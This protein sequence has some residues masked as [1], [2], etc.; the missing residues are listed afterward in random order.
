M[1]SKTSQLRHKYDVIYV[2]LLRNILYSRE[3][4]RQL[5]DRERLLDAIQNVGPYQP[6]LARQL[7][8][9]NGYPD[10][11]GRR[12]SISSE[13]STSS[14]VFLKP[15]S[16]RE[17]GPKLIQEEPSQRDLLF[18]EIKRAASVSDDHIYD[19]TGQSMIHKI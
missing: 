12:E 2:Q 7:S 17:L 5:T 16:Q 14:S 4:V 9:S 10:G 19:G 8:E 18:A 1:V 6:G 15:V 3:V 11:P 13:M